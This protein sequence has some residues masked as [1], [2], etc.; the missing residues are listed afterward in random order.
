[1]AGK[2]VALRGVSI[3]PACRI[4]FAF[5]GFTAQPQL[6]YVDRNRLVAYRPS[7]FN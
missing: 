7:R 2:A 1:M 5:D 6:V 4:T 3:A